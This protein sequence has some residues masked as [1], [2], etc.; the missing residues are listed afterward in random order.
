MEL[1]TYYVE[2]I[3]IAI[4]HLIAVASPGP[5]FAIVLKHSINYGR[6]IAIVT[7]IGVGTAILLHVTYALA[8]IGLFINSTPWVYDLLLIIASLFLIYLGSGAIRSPAP[9]THEADTN[10]EGLGNNT[11]LPSQAELTNKRAFIIGFMTNGLNPKATLFFLSLFTVVISSETPLFIQG[12]YGLYLA[13]ATACWF[14]FLSFLLTQRKVR[15][16]FV[17]RG[18][19][20][21]RIMGWVLIGLALHILVSE[22][23][24]K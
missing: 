21:D 2:F 8:G 19:I 16:V 20:F 23:V 22:F 14:C 11:Q 24:L 12:A 10:N 17:K 5:D 7:S 9:A 4:A 3:T 13:V 1:Q 18:Y 6:S 15:E